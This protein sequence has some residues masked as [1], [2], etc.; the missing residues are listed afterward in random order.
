MQVYT[1]GLSDLNK[2]LLPQ[3]KHPRM[4][5]QQIVVGDHIYLFG[6]AFHRRER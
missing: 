1:C 2:Q 4:R 5:V 3:M 6:E